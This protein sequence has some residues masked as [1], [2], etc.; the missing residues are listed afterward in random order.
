MK[1][2]NE[3]PPNIK[4][5][6]KAFGP[7]PKDSPIVFTYGDTIY[8][9]SKLEIDPHLMAHEQVHEIQQK[10]IGVELWWEKYLGDVQFRLK[11]ELEAYAVQYKWVKDRYTNGTAKWFLHRIAL[12][13]ASPMYG[14][15][16][17]VYE[18]ETK[19]RKWTK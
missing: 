17:G 7:M 19:I 14:S 16:I 11:Q 4:D 15:I 12:D 5:I 1:I 2:I 3:L 18:A 10:Q 6:E 9:P 13:L 8:N